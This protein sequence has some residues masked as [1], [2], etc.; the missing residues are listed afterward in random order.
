VLLAIQPDHRTVAEISQ[1]QGPQ[2]SVSFALEQHFNLALLSLRNEGNRR[3][4]RHPQATWAGISCQPELDLCTR[5][6]IA[7]V[8]SEH[9]SLLQIHRSPL[10]LMP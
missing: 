1:I 10:P 6:G 4:V 3:L 8:P 7:P 9:K 5:R 2:L